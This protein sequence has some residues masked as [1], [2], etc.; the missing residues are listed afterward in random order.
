[1][2]AIEEFP[3][4]IRFYEIGYF[5]IESDVKHNSLYHIYL[6]TPVD[7]FVDEHYPES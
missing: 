7:V 3:S 2:F 5:H 6:T 4:A 1:M